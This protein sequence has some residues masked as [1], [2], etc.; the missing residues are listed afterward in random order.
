MLV[1]VH[2]AVGL[3]LLA[4]GP[5]SATRPLVNGTL[6][7][8]KQLTGTPGSW[9]G[10]G[11]I[12]YAYQW[13][14]CNPTGAKC[15][16]IHGATK[17][18]Y[19]LVARDVG[20][21]L[22]LTVRATDGTGAT[23]AYSPLAGLVAAAAARSAVTAQPPVTGDAIVGSPV[24]VEAGTWTT[25]PAAVTYAWERC[26]ANGR[27]CTPIAGATTD[28]YSLTAVDAGHVLLAAVTAGG[29]T[30]LSLVT[31]LGR[32][33]PG[34]VAADRPTVTGPLQQGKR[35][36]AAAG[37]WAGTGTIAFAYQ[38]YRC[39]ATGARCSSIHGS[40]RATYTEVAADV[41]KTLGVTVRATD[42]TG[43]TSAY[44]ALAGLVAAASTT[45]AATA[46]PTL[47]GSATVGQ[48]LTVRPG[49]WSTAAPALAYAWLRCNA[50]G[51]LCTTIAAAAAA[52]TY[53]LTAAD[54][55]KAIVA[56][57]TAA[58]GTTRQ[59]VL[60]VASPAVAS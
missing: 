47:A 7:Q 1:P 52:S 18:T 28:T 33:S 3:A 42:T 4:G 5:T 23:A 35:L 30:A 50:N 37:S 21:T 39:S 60:T 49:T 6:Q 24:K 8:G 20:H 2:A 12:T 44:S 17:A 45:L 58:A 26:N 59:A 48:A 32:A 38:W 55:G 27:L 54:A 36:S 41:G 13:H 22:G 40:T 16:S 53:T 51:R 14:R 11:T 29:Q 34:P 9:V 56:S 25:A 15:S 43:T 57:V 46:Q 31:G 19:K 10:N